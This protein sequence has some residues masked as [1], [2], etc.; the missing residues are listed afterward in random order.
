MLDSGSSVLLAVSLSFLFGATP[1]GLG[2][3]DDDDEG[4]ED[5]EDDDDLLDDDDELDTD[6]EDAADVADPAALATNELLASMVRDML[7]DTAV[8]ETL[9]LFLHFHCSTS[10]AKNP[11]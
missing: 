1:V 10:V 8:Q 5:D 4:S 2:G 11:K 6:D 7:P 9:Q 3:G